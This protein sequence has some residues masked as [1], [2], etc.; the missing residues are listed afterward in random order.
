MTDR[1]VYLYKITLSKEGEDPLYYFG[2]R[3]CKC[4]PQN[5][6]FMGSPRTFKHLWDDQSYVKIKE[7][8]EIG[9][10]DKDYDRLRDKE[11]ILIEESW[12]QHGVYLDGGHSLNVRAG[13]IV[14]KNFLIGDNN[15]SKR[16]DVK[17]KLSQLKK[18]EY[19]T[20]TPPYLSED[21][22]RKAQEGINKFYSERGLSRGHYLKEWVKQIG[23]AHV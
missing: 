1:H 20:K 12:K 23:R 21:A 18:E 11:P 5:D 8:L 15:P 2:I 13:K 6:P 17:Q 19:K 22:K 3:V 4:L 16:Q 14:H 9:D 7:I 10:Y